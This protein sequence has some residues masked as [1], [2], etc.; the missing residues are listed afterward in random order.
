MQD[1]KLIAYDIV[2]T[3]REENEKWL[4]IKVDCEY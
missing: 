2:H 1:R 3:T 4:S